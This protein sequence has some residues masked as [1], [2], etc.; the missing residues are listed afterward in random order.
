MTFLDMAGK[1]WNEKLNN[2]LLKLNF[3]R[4]KSEPCVYIKTDRNNKTICILSVYVDNILIART[5]HEIKIVKDSI[6]RKFNI[7]D[8]SNVEFVIGIKFNKIENGYILHQIRYINDILFKYEINKLTPSKN[9][10]TSRK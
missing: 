4:A 10:N 8:I 5:D 9:F 3:R 6:K 7:K 2:E 1:E